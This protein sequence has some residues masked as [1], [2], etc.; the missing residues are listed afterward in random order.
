MG[1]V[2]S[3]AAILQAPGSGNFPSHQ[4]SHLPAEGGGGGGGGGRG[5]GRGGEGGE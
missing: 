1:A 4:M 3:V 5:G 2:H